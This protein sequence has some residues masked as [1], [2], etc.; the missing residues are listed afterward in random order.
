MTETGTD[1]NHSPM[2]GFTE[3]EGDA[4]SG[5]EEKPREELFDIIETLIGDYARLDQKYIH[6]EEEVVRLKVRNADLARELDRVREKYHNIRE[7]QKNLLEEHTALADDFETLN[8]LSKEQEAKLKSV[9]ELFKSF[10]DNRTERIMLIDDAYLIRYVNPGALL[11]LK[12]LGIPTAL[13]DRVFDLFDHKEA[14]KL[15]EKIDRVLLKG[16]TYKF[17]SIK[18]AKRGD[19]EKA[20]NGFAEDTLKVK[21]KLIRAT[22]KG[23]PSIKMYMK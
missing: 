9:N 4:M 1:S 19:G 13:G 5:Y 8:R 23:R 18:L 12:S 2:R 11:L 14:T 10:I 21:L 15:R 3:E 6:A 16:E 20:I 22:Y 17:K 7:K